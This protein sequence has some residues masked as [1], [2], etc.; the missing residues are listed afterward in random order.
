MIVVMLLAWSTFASINA[1]VLGNC[2]FKFGCMDEVQYAALFSSVAGAV[3]A[4]GFLAASGISALLPIQLSNRRRIAAGVAAGFI[5]SALL[6]AVWR[7]GLDISG[8]LAAW[9]AL[10]FSVSALALW[11][12]RR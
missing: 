5:L 3:S 10:S 2:D 11:V 4:A 8:M 7:W 9:L 12:H 1:F 6:A